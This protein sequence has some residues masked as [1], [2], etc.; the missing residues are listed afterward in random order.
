MIEY[1]TLAGVCLVGVGVALQGWFILDLNKRI[2]RLMVFMLK[3][4]EE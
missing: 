1:V 4:G 2:T 3:D